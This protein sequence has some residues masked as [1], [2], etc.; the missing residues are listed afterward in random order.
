[1][2]VFEPRNTPI[3][4]LYVLQLSGHHSSGLCVFA[5]VPKSTQLTLY[6]VY[7]YWS[8][9]SG[10]CVLAFEHMSTQLNFSRVSN[11]WNIINMLCVFAFDRL[12]MINCK[13]LGIRRVWDHENLKGI[14][15]QA[16]EYDTF[17]VH[18][19]MPC[20]IMFSTSMFTHLF[21]EQITCHSQHPLRIW[22]LYPNLG[23]GH[24]VPSKIGDLY[25]HLG[26][27]LLIHMCCGWH[28][29]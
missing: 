13:W 25:L 8:I 11:S 19:F 28:I 12:Y 24:W 26:R 22:N 20:K 2:F 18:L 4:P 15:W 21:L 1:M 29:N 23:K 9:I 27:S 3:E 17:E 14:K 7:S 5:I 16:Q 6:R 10:L